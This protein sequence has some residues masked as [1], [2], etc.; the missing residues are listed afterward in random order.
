MVDLLRFTSSKGSV[1]L[2]PHILPSFH[3]VN[4]SLHLC[5]PDSR[6]LVGIN[7]KTGMWCRCCLH[8]H[9][10]V[11]QWHHLLIPSKF[12]SDHNRKLRS[13]WASEK[14]LVACVNDDKRTPYYWE[15]LL[16]QLRRYAAHRE[17]TSFYLF[18]DSDDTDDTSKTTA[19]MELT[20]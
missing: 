15:M 7:P 16:N 13:A 10:R 11:W 8:I 9:I 1:P 14:G 3:Q 17:V 2:H 19:W 5:S 4:S 18:L 12:I 6:D 20:G